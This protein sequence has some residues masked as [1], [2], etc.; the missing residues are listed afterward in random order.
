MFDRFLLLVSHEINKINTFYINILTNFLACFKYIP[1]KY[2]LPNISSSHLDIQTAH[3]QYKQALINLIIMIINCINY[4]SVL[5]S[6]DTR[7]KFKYLI[8]IY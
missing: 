3:L 1:K 5:K 6:V 8:S 4:L 2:D 7:K